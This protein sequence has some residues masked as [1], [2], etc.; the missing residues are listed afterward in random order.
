MQ[1]Q[2][3]VQFLSVKI[4]LTVTEYPERSTKRFCNKINC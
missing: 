4:A 2:N 3:G 1:G